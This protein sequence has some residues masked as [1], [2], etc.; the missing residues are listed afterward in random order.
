LKTPSDKKS[1]RATLPRPFDYAKTFR[2]DW[3][4]LTK[5]GRYDMNRLKV[6]MALIIANE[7]P[8][9]PEYQDHSLQGSWD[10]FRDCHAGGDFILIYEIKADGSV[11]FSRTGTHSE[12]F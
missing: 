3:D 9:P 11:V 10:G 8:L 4:R 5:S 7:G 1:K 2:K 6:A 12:I